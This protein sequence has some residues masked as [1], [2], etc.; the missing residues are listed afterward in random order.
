[1]VS[2]LLIIE[3]SEYVRGDLVPSGFHERFL[4]VGTV[5]PFKGA[6]EGMNPP[7][8]KLRGENESR[9]NCLHPRR[10]P[11]ALSLGI[12]SAFLARSNLLWT[13]RA[14]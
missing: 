5:A 7:P 1:M 13:L 14:V 4:E 8:P 11:S 9:E 2:E 3:W 10:S 6:R 12:L